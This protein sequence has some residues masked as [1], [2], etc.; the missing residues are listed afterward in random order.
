MISFL[1]PTKKK[2]RN[3]NKNKNEFDKC[4]VIQCRHFF[5]VIVFAE[6]SERKIC[7]TLL[8][9]RFRFFFHFCFLRRNTKTIKNYL[10]KE[11]KRKEEEAKTKTEQNKKFFFF[12]NSFQIKI[13][14]FGDIFRFLFLLKRHLVQ[15]YSANISVKIIKIFPL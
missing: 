11:T 10:R 15:L 7:R 2:H 1:K 9:S 4:F 12:I 5:V 13:I 6:K 14:F 8:S 3:R